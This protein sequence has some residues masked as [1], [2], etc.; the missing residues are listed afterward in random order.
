MKKTIILIAL[1]PILLLLLILVVLSVKYSPVYLY[2]LITQNV[3]DVYD[4]RLYENRIVKGADNAFQFIKSPDKEFVEGL[5]QERVSHSGFKT[6]DEWAEKSQSTALI[7]IRRDTIL[8]EKY[9]NG[10]NR[11]SYFHSQSMAKSFISF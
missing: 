3:A 6:F 10:F 7:F 4:Y 1:T 11:D 5:F 8:Y 2:R 9:F